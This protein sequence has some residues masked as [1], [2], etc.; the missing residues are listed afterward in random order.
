MYASL[1]G[2]AKSPI[3]ESCPEGRNEAGSEAD[4]DRLWLTELC[5]IDVTQPEGTDN[6]VSD[7]GYTGEYT[8][9]GGGEITKASHDDRGQDEVSEQTDRNPDER[10]KPEREGF[11]YDHRNDE[12]FTIPTPI[13]ASR[14]ATVIPEDSLARYYCSR[15]PMVGAAWDPN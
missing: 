5:D 9:E 15:G 1:S 4:T 7:S 8:P 6:P 14:R 13:P 3:G 10:R 11:I 12:W 2:S